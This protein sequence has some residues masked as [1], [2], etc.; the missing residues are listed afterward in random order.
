MGFVREQNPTKM[1]LLFMCLLLAI[2][3]L[4]FSLLY[5]MFEIHTFILVYDYEEGLDEHLQLGVVRNKALFSAR[6]SLL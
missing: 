4:S 6:N 3:S 2:N 1:G 5:F